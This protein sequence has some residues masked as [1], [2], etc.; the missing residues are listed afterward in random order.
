[1]AVLRPSTSPGVL[2]PESYDSG[3][4]EERKEAVFLVPA[5]SVEL[6]GESGGSGLRV[7]FRL[8]ATKESQGAAVVGMGAGMGMG[9]EREVGVETI[10]LCRR[11]GRGCDRLGEGS[12]P[13]KSKCLV[14]VSLDGGATFLGVQGGLGSG[15]P[16]EV[17]APIVVATPAK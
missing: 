10:R 16:A 15:E 12:L 9:M 17:A 7:S 4:D 6:V 11:A 14:A 13:V 5:A 2:A 3:R 1:M 8:P